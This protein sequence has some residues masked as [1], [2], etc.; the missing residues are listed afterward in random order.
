[1]WWSR[2]IDAKHRAWCVKETLHYAKRAMCGKPYSV[3]DTMVS[4]PDLQEVYRLYRLI[5]WILSVT[6]VRVATAD[7]AGSLFDDAFLC[8]FKTS[9]ESRRIV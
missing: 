4:S 1:M 8:H 6:D 3:M 9:V 5:L 7:S 2:S